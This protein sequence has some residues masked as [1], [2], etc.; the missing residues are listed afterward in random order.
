LDE[1][2]LEHNSGEEKLQT[3]IKDF[4]VISMEQMRAEGA[5]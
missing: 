5:K 3:L 1:L 2:L 4:K